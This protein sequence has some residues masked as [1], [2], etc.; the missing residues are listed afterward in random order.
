MTK[1]HDNGESSVSAS[2]RNTPAGNVNNGGNDDPT[3]QQSDQR[4]QFDN[5][6]TPE[7]PEDPESYVDGQIQ[8]YTDGGLRDKRLWQEFR[9]DFGKWK[10]HDFTALNRI[11]RSNL[12][13]FLR[14][15]GVYV[16]KNTSI[17]KGMIQTLEESRPAMWPEA[18]LLDAIEDG[19]IFNS[20][21]NPYVAGGLAF[22][23]RKE[24]EEKEERRAT[25]SPKP[26]VTQP[27]QRTVTPMVTPRVQQG[28]EQARPAVQSTG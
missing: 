12:R 18:E 6:D 5:D 15:N 10:Q 23:K 13:N 8:F 20:S 27:L 26:E 1:N 21:L 25:L 16:D 24:R 17:P 28:S 9:M 3:S 11:Q 14:N 7:V 22:L 2:A 19:T 4:A